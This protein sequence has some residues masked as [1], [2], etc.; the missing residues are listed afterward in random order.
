M[1]A[2]LGTLLLGMMCGCSDDDGT[3][4]PAGDPS[5]EPTDTV[6]T[7]VVPLTWD[8]FLTSTDV[9]IYDKTD[10]SSLV[11]SRHFMEEK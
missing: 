4:A 5:V 1:L 3:P 9:Q 7:K 2:V 6:R 11:V 10:T 8:Q